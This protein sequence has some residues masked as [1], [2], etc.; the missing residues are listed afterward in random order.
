MKW[1][2]LDTEPGNWPRDD[3]SRFLFGCA[4]T[5]SYFKFFVSENEFIGTISKD[6]RIGDLICILFGGQPP[7]ILRI[8]GEDRYI[9]I[10][11]CYVT[12]STA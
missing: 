3:E 8:E 9:L 10:G 11:E 5:L 12:M 6:L 2:I 7:F 4:E 1:G